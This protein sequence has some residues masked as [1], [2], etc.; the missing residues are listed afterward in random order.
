MVQR[1]HISFYY[2]IKHILRLEDVCGETIF[3]EIKFFWFLFL[4]KGSFTQAK[5]I[6]IKRNFIIITHDNSKGTYEMPKRYLEFVGFSCQKECRFK[7]RLLFDGIVSLIYTIISI[8]VII[9]QKA[10]FIVLGLNILC[11]LRATINSTI[12]ASEVTIKLKKT[13]LEKR[14]IQNNH[15]HIKTIVLSC[16]FV[17]SVIVW[18]ILV[19]ENNKSLLIKTFSCISIIIMFLDDLEKKFIFAY[20]AIIEPYL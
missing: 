16:I 13:S 10:D 8:I 14:C 17:L 15:Y 12:S 20:N 6:Y 9:Y 5:K 19:Y 2:I 18:V 11:I 4:C 3:I 1:W 7:F